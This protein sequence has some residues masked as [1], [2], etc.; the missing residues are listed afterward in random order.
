[1]AG[2]IRLGTAGWVFEAWRK[3]Y[4][5]DGLKQKDEL[6]YSSARLGNIE[7]NATFYSHQKAA[8]F[9]NWASQTPDDFVFTVKAH[10]LVTHIKRLK[11]VELP[12]ANFFASGV[13]ALG[14]KLGPFCWQL[15]GNSKYDPDRMEAFLSL[16]PQTP[17][18]LVALAGKTDYGKNPPYLDATGIIRVRHAIEVRHESFADPRFI[19][20][21][22]AYNVALVVADTAEW[23]YIDQTADF[24]YARLQG[25]PGKESYALA[26]REV[27]AGWLKSWAE[28]KP[29]AGGPYVTAAEASPPPRD[30]FAFFVSTDKEHAPD[31]ARAVMAQLGLTGPGGE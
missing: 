24:S 17:E 30:V 6:A 13:M 7:I 12:L 1:M 21:L 31:N 19:A 23:A 9:E 18:A 20:Q 26:E 28:G 14:K 27:R 11:D 15:P 5:P 29:V 25:A 3:S 16:L 8:S 22:R 4:Y 10:Q 2:T